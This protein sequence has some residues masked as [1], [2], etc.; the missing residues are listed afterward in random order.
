MTTTPET[1]Y[2]EVIVWSDWFHSDWTKNGILGVLVVALP[3]SGFILSMTLYALIWMSLKACC[4][5]PDSDSADYTETMAAKK[6]EVST[7][8]TRSSQP[9]SHKPRSQK[10]DPNFTSARLSTVMS[11]EGLKEQFQW[12]LKVQQM[13]QTLILNTQLRVTKVNNAKETQIRRAFKSAKKKER[14]E[15]KVII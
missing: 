12:R 8:P 11:M 14:K 4:T 3:I 13:L 9:L 5:K 7:M 15:F 2:E 6:S 10:N 1:S